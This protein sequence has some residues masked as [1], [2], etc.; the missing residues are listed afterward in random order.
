MKARYEI[1][2]DDSMFMDL[3]FGPDG[4]VTVILQAGPGHLLDQERVNEVMEEV[5]RYYHINPEE[6]EGS[7]RMVRL[8][9]SGQKT[10]LEEI[11]L[12]RGLPQQRRRRGTKKSHRRNR[13]E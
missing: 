8:E 10:F 3:E 5:G 1:P 6:W 7:G 13:G 9:D 4:R 12:P 11:T 2:G